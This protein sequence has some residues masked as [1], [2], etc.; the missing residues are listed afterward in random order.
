MKFTVTAPDGRTLEIEGDHEPSEAEL[1]EIFAQ[2]PPSPADRTREIAESMGISAG[3]GEMGSTIV[4]GAV[5]EPLAGL[6][7]LVRGLFTADGE[8]ASDTVQAVQSALTYDPKTPEGK[9]GLESLATFLGP[10]ARVL[11]AVEEGAGEVGY[12]AGRLL[13]AEKGAAAAGAVMRAVPAALLEA[14][15]LKGVRRVRGA[16]GVTGVSDDVASAAARA[17]I[18]VAD[19]ANVAKLQEMTAR[20]AADQARRAGLF[21][22]LEIPTTRSRI[23]Q[24]QGDFLQERTLAR[25]ADTPEGKLVQDRLVEEAIGFKNAATRLQQQL[26]I[27]DDAGDA[28]K[29]ALE[30]RLTNL[31]DAKRAAYDELARVSAGKGM[32]LAGDEVLGTLSSPEVAALAGRLDPPA[33]AKLNDL[34]VEYGLDTDTERVASWVEGRKANAGALPVKADVTPLSV[35]NAEDFRQALNNLI[36]P[37]GSKEL[38]GIAK[39]LIGG[40]DKELGTLDQA[41][42]AADKAGQLGDLGRN[43]RDVMAAA[44]RAREIARTEFREFSPKGIVGMLTAAKR[45][46]FDRDLI[47]ASEVTKKLLS[48]NQAGSLE[49]IS[50]V[51]DSLGKAGKQG[52]KAIGDLQAAVVMDLLETATKA[53]SAKMAEGVVDWSGTA[54]SKRFDEIGSKKLRRIFQNNPKALDMLENLKEAGDLRTSLAAVAKASGTADDLINFFQKAGFLSKLAG[55]GSGTVGLITVQGLETATKRAQARAA[56]VAA[57]KQLRTKPDARQTVQQVKRLY[58]NMAVALGIGALYGSEEPHE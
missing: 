19:P 27:P 44:R 37:T 5:A 30:T 25:A 2:A 54:F 11:G 53:R 9:A 18:N 33:R 38:N 4:S 6:A 24:G 43:T 36:D 49:S 58:P 21:E 34:M 20:E 10:L 35:L 1:Q 55:I 42:A 15:G 7:G 47:V 40:L 39:A 12:G 41:L 52:E 16:T 17:G 23:T 48:G 50:E 57:Q 14:L 22:Q 32:P 28:I 56:R 46:T 31:K 51:M 13:G 29:E 8:G 3:V 26:G 45:G